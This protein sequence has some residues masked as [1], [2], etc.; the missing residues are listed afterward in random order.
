MNKIF[1]NK[2]LQNCTKK[3]D[4]LCKNVNMYQGS[5]NAIYKKRNIRKIYFYLSSDSYHNIMKSKLDIGV[6]KNFDLEQEEYCF[7]LNA[8]NTTVTLNLGVRYRLWKKV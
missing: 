3:V 8:I 6:H 7:D 2:N 4:F 1:K 5:K